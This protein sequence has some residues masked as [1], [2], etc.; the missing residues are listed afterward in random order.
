MGVPWEPTGFNEAES[1]SAP[2]QRRRTMQLILDEVHT[3]QK[4]WEGGGQEWAEASTI[5]SSKVVI[6]SVSSCLAD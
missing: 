6:V 1:S 3:L 2:G 5:N 4:E